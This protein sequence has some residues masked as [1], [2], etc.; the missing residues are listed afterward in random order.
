[1]APLGGNL[2]EILGS[3][4]TTPHETWAQPRRR[5]GQIDAGGLS[6]ID[7]RANMIL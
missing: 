6:C 4:I 3:S 7:F 2:I 1:M 5:D